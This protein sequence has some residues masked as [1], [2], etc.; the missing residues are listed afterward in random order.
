MREVGQDE[1]EASAEIDMAALGNDPLGT[2]FNQSS[3]STKS[4]PA[5]L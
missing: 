2:A 5:L 4:L 1:I 3:R